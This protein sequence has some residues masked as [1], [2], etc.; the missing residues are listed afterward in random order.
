[1]K[2]SALTVS[3]AKPKYKTE[4]IFKIQEPLVCGDIVL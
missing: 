4:A 1:M 2:E 3:L